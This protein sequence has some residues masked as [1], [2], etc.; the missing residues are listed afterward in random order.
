MRFKIAFYCLW[1]A[2][3]FEASPS[4]ALALLCKEEKSV[5]F[6]YEKDADDWVT[7]RFKPSEFSFV[8]RPPEE[9]DQKHIDRLSFLF[10]PGPY[11]YITSVPDLGIVFNVC[12]DPPN[13]KG[14]MRCPGSGTL[15]ININTK[16]FAKTSSSTMY[17]FKFEKDKDFDGH[18]DPF[19][20][21][22]GKCK[23]L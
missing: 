11:S 9:K 23:E 1:A 7:T 17:V 12:P 15:E 16:R 2:L 20:I 10:P 19:Q 8:L 21:R 6:S 3:I 13:A 18:V 5:G 22:I 14:F 4:N